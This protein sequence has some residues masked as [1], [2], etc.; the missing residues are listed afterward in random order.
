MSQMIRRLYLSVRR[1]ENGN[2]TISK[3]LQKEILEILEEEIDKK[4]GSEFER[5][6]D[7]AFL[8]GSAGGENGFVKGFKYAYHLFMECASR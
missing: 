7:A 5:I 4:E 8:I 2:D 1:E 6:R 3:E